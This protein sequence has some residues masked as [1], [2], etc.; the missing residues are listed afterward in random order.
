MTITQS[1]T[2]FKPD[3]RHVEVN[4]T[5]SKSPAQQQR[6]SL[7]SPASRVESILSQSS[8]DEALLKELMKLVE[9]EDDYEKAE[10]RVK[11]L[12]LPREPVKT[13]GDSTDRYLGTTISDGMDYHARREIS[14]TQVKASGFT[15]G[16]MSSPEERDFEQHLSGIV[17]RQCS[18]LIFS[19]F[20][21]KL[22]L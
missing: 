18:V 10:E 3:K 16:H 19:S 13:N 22:R 4:R 20:K 15:P 1:N 21:G 8:D 11:S 12:E 7:L 14:P 2:T 9:N 17:S 5:I 6:S